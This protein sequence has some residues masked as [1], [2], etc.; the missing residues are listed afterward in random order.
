MEPVQAAPGSA[1][2]TKRKRKKTLQ[3]AGTDL[4]QQQILGASS[5]KQSARPE[6]Y[7]PL[8]RRPNFVLHEVRFKRVTP[9][10]RV[11]DASS[12]DATATIITSRMSKFAGTVANLEDRGCSYT[13]AIA[14][15]TSSWSARAVYLHD[16]YNPDSIRLPFVLHYGD[17]GCSD[18]CRIA[19]CRNAQI[20][21]VCTE[22][23]CVWDELCSNRPRESNKVEVEK[24]RHTGTYA[25][26]ANAD[27]KRGEVLEEYLNRLRYAETDRPKRDSFE[28]RGN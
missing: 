9:K 6:R 25:L 14:F 4:Q 21:V 3:Y 23:C 2:S 26:V 19:T 5:G 28:V 16:V 20:N 8:P 24:D 1:T 13:R 10:A 12:P 27:L 18:P 7:L 22:K 17:C 11:N 15:V